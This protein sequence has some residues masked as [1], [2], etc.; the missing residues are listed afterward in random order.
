VLIILWMLGLC[1]G[2]EMGEFIH[3]FYVAAVTLLVVDLSQEVM[4]NRRLRR[5]SRG[6]GGKVDIG[7]TV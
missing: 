6:H 7:Q 1:S 4:I 3:V 2:F 5:A